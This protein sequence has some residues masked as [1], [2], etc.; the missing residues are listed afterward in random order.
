MSRRQQLIRRTLILCAVPV[1]VLGTWIVL[2]DR[3]PEK[4]Y[5]AGAETEGITRALDRSDARDSDAS[6]IRFTDVT[7]AAGIDFRHFPFPRTSQL[8]EDMGSGVAWGDYDGDGR[9]DLFLVNLAAPLTASDSEMARSTATDRLYRNRGDGTFED[10]TTRSGVGRPHRGQGAA[11]ADFDADGHLDLFVTCFGENVLWRNRGDGT[12]EDVTARAGL[13]GTG[14]WTGAA[15]S[16]FDVDGDLDLYVC[17]YVRYTPRAPG[18]EPE[19]SEFPF[20][21]NPSSWPPHPNRLFA[22]QGDGT[23]RDVSVSA[24]VADSS[25]KSLCAAWADLDGDGWP[26]LYVA[27][28]VSDNVLYRNRH[29]GTFENVSYE[30]VVA[31]YRGAMGIAVGDWDRDLDLDLFITHWIAQ[32][33][34]L[35]SNQLADFADEAGTSLLFVDDADRVGLGQIALDLIGWGTAFADFDRD[36][37]LDLFVANGSTFQDRDDPSR[38]VPMDA[39]LYWNRGPSRGFFEVGAEAGVRATAARVGRGGAVADYDGDGDLDLVLSAHGGAARLLRNDSTG[40]H[41]V[42]LRLRGRRGHPSGCGAR[43]VLH[44]GGRAY[45]QE[46]GA[47]PSYL[48]QSDPELVIG[49]GQATSID[50]LRID[51]PGGHRDEWKDLEVDRTWLLEEGGGVS[52]AA[53]T[54]DDRASAETDPRVF[55][56]LKKEAD[57]LLLDGRWQEAEVALAHL[58]ELDPR[59]EDSIYYRGN[60]LLELA[61]YDEAERTWRRLLEVNP[62]ASRAWVQIGIVHSMP[63]AGDLF[64]PG[65][66]AEAFAAAHDINREESGPVIRRGEALLAAGD[67]S[68]AERVLTDAYRM[69]DQATSALFLGGYLAWKRGEHARAQELLAAARTS[70]DAAP[71]PQGVAGEGDTRSAQMAAIRH[72]AGERRL[73]ADCVA[74]LRSRPEASPEELFACVDAARA[75]LPPRR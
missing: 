23:F 34:A 17:G 56:K 27:N 14:F 10:V 49:L 68:A 5:V 12:F 20:T 26:D 66:A 21:L 73:F 33:N 71:P 47:G 54:G 41:G 24:G 16:D 48:S 29:D 70:T 11:W 31:D 60:S 62:R 74:A 67:L 36:G 45:L 3:A 65:A 39:H 69:N 6:P 4:P 35:Y 42:K 43:V 18:A 64:D 55:W 40:G 38:L 25:G 19:N 57:Q 53:S 52:L 59:H 72:R 7:D 13:S 50:S 9:P 30:A 61:R 44:A 15:W 51:W 46:A 28:D 22:N 2:R 58:S 32:E 63:E 1:A 37:W 75:A 8:P